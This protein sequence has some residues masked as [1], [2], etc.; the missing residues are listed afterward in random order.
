MSVT[1]LVGDCID[2]P[3]NPALIFPYPPDHFQNHS[4]NAMESNEHVLVTAHTG[5]GKTTVAEYAVAHGI[6]S[7]K[8]VI[9][10]APIKALSNQIYG[11]F[12]RKYPNWSL[13]IRTGDIDYRSD[14]AQVIIMT[15]EI[16]QNMLYKRDTDTKD[17]GSV[18]VLDFN[19]VSIVIFDEVH[20]IKDRERGSVWERSIMMMPKHIQMIMLSA[21]LPDADNFCQWIAECSN[22]NVTHTTTPIR[23]VPLTHYILTSKGKQM[24]MDKDGK[25]YDSVYLNAMK[26]YTFKS[27]ELDDYIPMIS[28]PALFFCFSK[29]HCQQYARQVKIHLTSNEE[30]ME[31]QKLLASLIRKFP[32]HKELMT[33]DQTIDVFRLASRGVCYHHAGLLPPL[34]EIIQELFSTGLI[35]VLFV[36]ETFAAGVNMPAKTV[37]FTGLTK[38]D[39]H[40]S[41]FRI[42]LPEEYGQMSGRAG[43]RGMDT[44]GTVIHLPF[45]T[46]HYP[47]QIHV[48]EMMCGK[49]RNIESRIKPDYH[50]VFNI[51]L[52][53]KN[54]DRSKEMLCTGSML[55]KQTIMQL[56]YCRTQLGKL[57]S[58]L[59][60]VETQIRMFEKDNTDNT[61]YQRLQDYR[62]F[63]DNT[64]T[65]KERKK[66]HKSGTEDWYHDNQTTCDHLLYLEDRHSELD[67]SIY[68]LQSE[69]YALNETQTEELE[70][71][72]EFLTA[73]DY[74][75]K[76]RD[77]QPKQLS[78]YG[79]NDITVKGIMASGTNE[80]NAILLTELIIGGYLDDL[81][82][83]ELIA[84]LAIFL[85]TKKSDREINIPSKLT[86]LI[87]QISTYA[88]T[89][90]CAESKYS[91]CH[92]DW[93]VYT[94]FCDMAYHWAKTG[95]IDRVYSETCSE[96]QVGHFARMM[97][98]LN[99]I[100]REALRSAIIY[101]NDKLCTVLRECP[102]LL[103]R[104]VIFPQ[105][106]Y[107][108]P[109][110]K[111][112][113]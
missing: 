105:S 25:F 43:R 3:K 23:V 86:N 18:P 73:N 70:D 13:G 64:M 55:D 29:K 84:I 20:Y 47:D 71:L 19:N 78:D 97:M 22:R 68:K 77:D 83:Y 108:S 112:K 8:R 88:D 82:C 33:L 32:N 59:N 1:H 24:I 89:F 113:G 106:L 31:I 10:T 41:G 44:T 35:K 56:E 111:K 90:S 61:F 48:K 54:N 17:D 40:G 101:Q 30:T 14:D 102:D 109:S 81:D 42:L 107:V 52:Y 7:G 26:N 99:N 2:P 4:F 96:I 46:Y 15:T 104:G 16:L 9:Y 63:H 93:S 110:S 37:V 5:S 76:D 51:I 49:I 94:E 50:H 80:A 39:D 36:T 91:P 85:A 60:S 21:T 69:I 67:T 38:Y 62:K 57:E 45:N 72:T 103:I 58:E 92:S 65:S 74:L 95:I 11:D 53:G 87:S 75:S 66:Y 28:L 79:P 27:A 34:K 98:K 12:S 100:C 6:K